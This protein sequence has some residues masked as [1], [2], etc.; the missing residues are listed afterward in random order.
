MRNTIQPP[1]L[2]VKFNLAEKGIVG[3]QLKK[4]D[5]LS[6]EIE[7]T[8][9]YKQID[10]LIERWMTAFSKKQQPNVELPIIFDGLPP[11]TLRVLTILRSI[12]F[13]VSLTY[14]ELAEISGTP[15]GA[16]AVGNA[17]GRNPCPLIV[18][19]HRVLAQNGLGGFTGGIEVKKALLV[20]E[21]SP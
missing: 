10:K 4:A 7:G 5:S 3:V 20:F 14:Q 12:P 1:K 17:C 2:N 21:E 6:W 18:P 19:C 13:G 16:R 11:F 9:K 15:K 8:S